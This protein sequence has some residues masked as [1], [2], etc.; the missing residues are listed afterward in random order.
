MAAGLLFTL[1]LSVQW[2]TAT[3]A[4]AG[5]PQH[6]DRS[7]N[8]GRGLQGE[9]VIND[10]AK[11]S[12]PFGKAALATLEAMG[13]LEEVAKDH[14]MTGAELRRVLESGPSG[15]TLHHSLHIN[16]RFP[17]CFVVN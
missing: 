16:Q 17:R 4:C 13:T 10:G 2:F 3:F 7:W 9:G 5:H 14:K 6:G 12:T 1:L 11:V 8:A 15:I